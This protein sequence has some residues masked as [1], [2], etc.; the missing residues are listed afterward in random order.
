MPIAADALPEDRHPGLLPLQ[1]CPGGGQRWPR[2]GKPGIDLPGI[3]LRQQLT[4]VTRSPTA[5]PFRIRPFAARDPAR[6]S[7][8]N[9]IR[10]ASRTMPVTLSRFARSLL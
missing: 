8:Y 1:S 4:R 9:K 3:G 10:F 7:N 5:M 2:Q 6:G